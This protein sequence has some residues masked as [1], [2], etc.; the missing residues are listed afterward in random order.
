MRKKASVLVGLLWCM[1]L[2]SVVVISVLHTAR[3]DLMVQK[4]YADQI[5][6]RYLA[7]AGIEKAK[8]LLY[9]EAIERRT[10]RKNHTGKLFDDPDEFRQVDLGPGQFSVLRRGND[11]EGGGIIYGIADEE[12]RLNV[13]YAQAEELAKIDGMSPDIVA[14]IMDW[15]DEDKNVS[16]GGAEDEYYMGLQP[17]RLPRSGLFQSTKELLMVR[18][19][20]SATLLGEK[21]QGDELP[22]SETEANGG[23]SIDGG[24]AA[25][26]GVDGWVQNLNAAGDKRIPVQTASEKA[27][28]GITGITPEIAK[29]IVTRRQNNKFE[30]LADLLEA[31]LTTSNPRTGVTTANDNGP[32]A[33]SDDLLIRIADDVAVDSTSEIPGLIN[34]NTAASEVLRCLGGVTPE[35]AQAIVTHRR[36]NGFF[37]NVAGVLKVA[38]MT[39]EIFKQVAPRITVR[40]E[41]FRLVSEGVVTST[42]ARHRIQ[43]IVHVGPQTVET[44][45][46]REDL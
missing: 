27:L 25:L 38:G 23:D 6:A 41:T 43:A 45:S 14:A 26:L 8:A 2:L 42:G 40:S 30:S 29:A 17:P 20:T 46:Y 1:A 37:E 4:N 9:H 5:Q 31:P 7:L 33:V 24:W 11:D 13:N 18:G 10:A 21:S 36:S 16:P 34:I 15:R 12:S 3:L 19:I 22:D 44:L 39:H 28:T 32:K 35:L